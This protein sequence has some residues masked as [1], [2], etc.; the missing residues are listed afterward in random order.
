MASYV[1]QLKS[2]LPPYAQRFERVLQKE[3]PLLGEDNKLKESFIYSLG[4]AAKRFRPA[5][6]YMIADSISGRNVDLSAFAVECF[7]AASLVA[8]DLPCMDN[9]D[10]RRGRPT[11]HKVYGD[12]TALLASFALIAKGFEAIARNAIDEVGKKVLSRAVLEASKSMGILGL[13]GGQFID[14]FP[15]PPTR[16]GIEKIHEM[17]TVCLFDLSMTLGWL[18]GGGA[19]ESL[20][21]IHKSAFH[22]GSAFQIVDDI[23]DYDQDLKIGKVH[24]FAVQFGLS[25]AK[26]AVLEHTEN[27]CKLLSKLKITGPLL[28]LTESFRASTSL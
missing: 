17:K 28:E 4:G 7:H 19:I 20:E 23:D 12:S 26:K 21:D 9:D 18:F 24:N 10:F 11:V 25:E 5:L 6:V 14:L 2:I 8:D 16:Q 22:F 1:H 15:D 13:I 3:I 27:C